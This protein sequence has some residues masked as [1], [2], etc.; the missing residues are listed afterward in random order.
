MARFTDAD[1][2]GVLDMARARRQKWKIGLRLLV[3]VVLL[4]MLFKWFEHS[5][6]YVPR[7]EWAVSPEVLGH[8]WKDVAIETDDGVRLSAWFFPAASDSPRRHLA[9]VIS[10]GNGGNISHRLSLYDICYSLGV[11]VLAYDYRGYGKSQGRPYEEGTYNDA[12]AAYQWLRQQ[13]FS[14]KH[15]IAYGESLG[16]AVA[17]ELALREEVGALV[18]QSTFTSIPDMG[19]R[20]FPWLPV[21]LLSSIRYDT[22]EK[23]PRLTLPLLVMHSPV[24]SV[25]PFEQGRALFEAANEPKRFVRLQADHN[26]PLEPDRPTIVAAM[27]NLLAGLSSGGSP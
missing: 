3:W 5:Q 7:A 22:L 4:G 1:G 25:V 9:I 11:N 27:E 21:R 14:P 20:L 16:G 17:A 15:I 19:K 6:V 26:D 10:H 8:P 13:G 18:L 2:E 24:D 12:V 23:V